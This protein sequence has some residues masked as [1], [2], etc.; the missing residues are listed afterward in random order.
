MHLNHCENFYRLLIKVF[1]I[2]GY[3]VLFCL[4]LAYSQQPTEESFCREVPF[5]VEN[6]RMYVHGLINDRP[7]RFMFDTGA[8]GYG[9]IDSAVVESLNLAIT[10]KSENFDGVNRSSINNVKVKSIKFAGIQLENVTLLSRNYNRN[11]NNKILHGIIGQD[12]WKDYLLEIDNKRQKLIFSKKSLSKDDP[13]TIAY[14]DHFVI[15]IQ[16]GEIKAHAAIDTGSTLA[17]HIPLDFAQKLNVSKLTEAGTARRAYTTFTFW[18]G[19]IFDEI[20]IAG[21]T[22]KNLEVTFSKA[23]RRINI[24]MGFLKN[25]NIAI[26]QKNGLITLEKHNE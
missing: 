22:E 23:A 12:F 18:K 7:Y 11:Q 8:S 17:M 15:P 24:G 25:Y 20:K 14:E 13:N 19:T 10:G 5:E 16:I 4:P 26:D 1:L 9:R 3:V 6:S 21:N 2:N